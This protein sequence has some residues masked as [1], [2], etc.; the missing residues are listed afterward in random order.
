MSV[1]LT[2]LRMA[3]RLLLMMSSE[4]GARTDATILSFVE[5]CKL[6]KKNVIGFFKDFFDMVVSERS[7]YDQMALD[8]LGVNKK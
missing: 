3:A 5:T 7:D 1:N 4:N 8:I 2:S 6:M